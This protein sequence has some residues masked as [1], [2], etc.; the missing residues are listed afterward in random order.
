MI[1][2]RKKLENLA[3]DLQTLHGTMVNFSAFNIMKIKG[4]LKKKKTI[5][6]LSSLSLFDQG[7]KYSKPFT[8]DI[9]VELECTVFS[10]TTNNATSGL[11][12]I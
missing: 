9:Y 5:C 7:R 6:S 11:A 12:V 1:N 2:V 4:K 8:E 10:Q 3:L